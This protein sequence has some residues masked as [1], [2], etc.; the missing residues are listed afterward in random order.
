MNNLPK[1]Y[2][3]LYE[4]A[5]KICDLL[6]SKTPKISMEDDNGEF[7]VMENNNFEAKFF[8]VVI[9]KGTKMDIGALI[10]IR[11]KWLKSK[12]IR[13]WFLN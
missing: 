7:V 13:A 1:K 8:F 5:K 3:N 12:I 11:L 9:Y 2:V 4:Y 10:K 6:K